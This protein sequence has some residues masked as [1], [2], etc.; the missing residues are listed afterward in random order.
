VN[1]SQDLSATPTIDQT[2]TTVRNLVMAA[3]MRTLTN[4]YK[5]SAT[6]DRKKVLNYTCAPITDQNDVYM[7]YIAFADNPNL[8]CISDAPPRCPVHIMRKHCNKYFWVPCAAAPAFLDLCMQ[9]TFM[10]GLNNAVIPPG[11][12]A[13]TIADVQKVMAVEGRD[14]ANAVLVFDKPV[15]NGEGT[16]VVDLAN[17]SKAQLNLVMPIDKDPST[18]KLVDPGQLTTRLN[19]QWAPKADM[20]TADQMKGRPARFYSHDFPPEV[21][22]SS[23]ILQQINANVNTISTQVQLQNIHP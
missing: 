12:Y 2:V 23:P 1:E 19:L 9:T 6:A 13:V 15:P 11:S 3:A 18:N 10:R 17:G 5:I 14:I 8:F 22:Q 4:D 7:K 21:Q 20:V 16:L